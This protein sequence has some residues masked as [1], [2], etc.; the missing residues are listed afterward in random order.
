MGRLKLGLNVARALAHHRQGLCLSTAYPSSKAPLLWQCIAGR[1]WFAC[2]DNVNNQNTWCPTCSH[3]RRRL[4]LADAHGVA[5]DRNGLC[6]STTYVD[7]HKA[8]LWQ[9]EGGHKWVASLHSVKARKSWCPTCCRIQ[10]RLGLDAA[11]RV[12]E[13]R[14]GK[15]LSTEYENVRLPLTW[16]CSYGHQWRTALHN[17]KNN[18][19]WCPECFWTNQKL[20]ILVAR[21]LAASRKVACLSTEYINSSAPM[22][23]RCEV[24][25]TWAAQFRSL[26]CLGTWCPMCSGKRGEQHVRDLFRP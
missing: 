22:I 25:H 3:I 19:S 24:G 2:L 20:D 8:L 10:G 14:G 23:W 7:G 26:R 18:G 11:K 15:C 17:V 1:Q 9:C 21:S 13:S 6:L 12:A 5:H 4:T 16:T